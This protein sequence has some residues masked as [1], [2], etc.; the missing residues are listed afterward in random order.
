MT[1]FSG[2]SNLQSGA[3]PATLQLLQGFLLNQTV[4]IFISTLLIHSTA[5]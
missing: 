4:A 1:A 2:K 5:Q 3:L